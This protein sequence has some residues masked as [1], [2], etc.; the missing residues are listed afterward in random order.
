MRC[1]YLPN[2][3]DLSLFCFMFLFVCFVSVSLSMEIGLSSTF[4]ST[5]SEVQVYLK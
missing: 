4:C 1:L 3:F 5:F 2:I